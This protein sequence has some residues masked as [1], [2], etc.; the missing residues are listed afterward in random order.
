MVSG[1]ILQ[2]RAAFE[3]ADIVKEEDGPLTI[4]LSESQYARLQVVLAGLV[5]NID[6][7]TCSGLMTIF[8][9]IKE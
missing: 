7:N 8:K 4:G 1:S 2:L 5:E 9:K 3:D 6:E